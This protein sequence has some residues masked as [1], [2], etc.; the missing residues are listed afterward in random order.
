M[1]DL[2]ALG[3]FHGGEPL[4]GGENFPLLFFVQEGIAQHE[5]GQ[6]TD[7]AA[8]ALFR[9]YGYFRKTEGVYVPVDSPGRDAEMLRQL[10]CGL[11]FF[12]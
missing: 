9:I 1:Q 12:V 10:F 7:A 5:I 11:A 2:A 3:G 4:Q 6:E 8:F